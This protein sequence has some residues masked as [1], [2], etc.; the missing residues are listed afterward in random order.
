[1]T[2]KEKE[3]MRKDIAEA[4][5]FVRYLLKNPR[6]IARIKNNGEIRFCPEHPVRTPRGG[7]GSRRVQYFRSENVFR[8]L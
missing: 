1:M 2:R 5:D 6:Q 3:G 4:F 7:G 8:P